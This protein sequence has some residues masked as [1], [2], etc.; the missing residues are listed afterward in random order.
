LNSP[1][2]AVVDMQKP[3]LENVGISAW[4]GPRPNVTAGNQPRAAFA[5]R[6]QNVSR[7]DASAH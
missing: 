7:N 2:K 1:R 4:F 5:K 3:D 6:I